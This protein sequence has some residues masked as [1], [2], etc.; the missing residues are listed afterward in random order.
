MTFLT[1]PNKEIN[2]LVLIQQAAFQGEFL[3]NS[4][5]L[6]SPALNETLSFAKFEFRCVAKLKF[7]C[8]C[9][10]GEIVREFRQPVQIWLWI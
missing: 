4:V 8:I 6:F 1:C 7:G 3:N 9:V 2:C 5:S 10:V